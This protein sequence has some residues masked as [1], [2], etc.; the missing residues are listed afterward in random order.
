MC[1]YNY[2]YLLCMKLQPTCC[3]SYSRYVLM[4]L[5]VC[6]H[7]YL[8]LV[9]YYIKHFTPIASVLLSK[10]FNASVRQIITWAQTTC[11]VSLNLNHWMI[12]NIVSYLKRIS[13]HYWILF[14]ELFFFIY[15]TRSIAPDDKTA[16]MAH[17]IHRL[18]I[19]Y[20]LNFIIWFSL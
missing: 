19:K 13:S 9:H 7:G 15:S 11:H 12:V 4:L 18:G 10:S 16:G 2:M 8:S 14:L 3:C 5:Y 20:M 1:I 6:I 17:D